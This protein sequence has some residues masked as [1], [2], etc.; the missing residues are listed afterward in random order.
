MVSDPTIR[1]E[2]E[3]EGGGEHPQLNL[4]KWEE[5]REERFRRTENDDSSQMFNRPPGCD[6]FK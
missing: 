2:E 1:V 6:F 3:E 4:E 5:S